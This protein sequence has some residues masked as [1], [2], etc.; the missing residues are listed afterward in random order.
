VQVGGKTLHMAALM[1]KTG[2]LIAMDLYE[3]KLKQLKIRAKRDG[4]FRISII[5]SK[6][7]K[8]HQKADRVLIDA[9]C[10]GLGVLKRNPDAKWKLKPEFIDNTQNTG[11][12][13]RKLFENCKTR[14][15]NGLCYL[16]DI[17]IKIRSLSF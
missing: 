17:K 8:L 5:D 1:E 9:P 10:S 6:V 3:S 4:A 12:S 13:L 14:R 16:L 15:K 11:G 7:K 2:L